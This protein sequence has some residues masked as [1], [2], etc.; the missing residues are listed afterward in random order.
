MSA[1]KHKQSI[2]T[3]KKNN[4]KYPCFQ[5]ITVKWT[6]ITLS[7]I[8]HNERIDKYCINKENFNNDPGKSN[9]DETVKH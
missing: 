9:T 2:N 3:K 4:D 8:F 7:I 5:S 6:L 1:W